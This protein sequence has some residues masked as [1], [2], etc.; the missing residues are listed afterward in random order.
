LGGA[1]LALS[2][3]VGLESPAQAATGSESGTPWT[4]F[5]NG[6][7]GVSYLPTTFT[8]GDCREVGMNQSPGLKPTSVRL[9]QTD[10]GVANYYHFQWDFTLYTVSTP[11]FPFSA[12]VWHGTWIFRTASGA[13]VLRVTM[14]GPQMQQGFMFDDTYDR[15]L[16][17]TPQEIMSIATVNWSG[18]C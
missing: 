3:T 11:F 16:F 9:T 7:S 10:N 17:I 14:D 4:W 18:D 8:A 2:A 15:Y 1:A 12:D 6:V 5:G 13:E